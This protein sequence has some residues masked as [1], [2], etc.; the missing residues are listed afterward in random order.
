MTKKQAHIELRALR[1][2]C[3][4]KV[5][6]LNAFPFLR[7]FQKVAYQYGC[8]AVD[9]WVHKSVKSITEPGINI[10]YSTNRRYWIGEKPTK[11]MRNLLETIN[12]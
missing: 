4:C 3:I 6:L 9:E 5:I 10:F 2:Y 12:L 7:K 11:Y 8:K 1:R